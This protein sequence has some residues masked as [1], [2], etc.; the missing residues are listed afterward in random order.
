MK[1]AILAAVAAATLAGLAA[2]SGGAGRIT[3]KGL[4]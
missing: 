3:L 2:K 1:K 4:R